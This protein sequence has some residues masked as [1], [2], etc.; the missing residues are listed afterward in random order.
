MALED[1]IF[2]DEQDYVYGQHAPFSPPYIPED[3]GWDRRVSGVGQYLPVVD[4]YFTEQ[5]I[6]SDPALRQAQKEE[7]I[8]RSRVAAVAALGLGAGAGYLLRGPLK[9]LGSAGARKILRGMAKR[10]T[11]EHMMNFR[12]NPWE[13]TST[14]ASNPRF[15]PHKG[16]DFDPFSDISLSDQLQGSALGEFF[17][18]LPKRLQNKFRKAIQPASKFNPSYSQADI[19][20]SIGRYIPSVKEIN[21]RK[22]SAGDPASYYRNLRNKI[23]K[24]SGGQ[25]K[26]PGKK[27]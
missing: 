9:A 5:H 16:F 10:D 8:Q 20:A 26:K 22:Y 7:E 19:D 17:A 12:L 25:I 13:F 1:Y 23:H 21:V 24:A 14:S 3:A 27:R 6:M 2:E 18:D 15:R 11:A 4:Q